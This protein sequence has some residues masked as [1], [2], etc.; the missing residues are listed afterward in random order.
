MP[1]VTLLAAKDQQKPVKIWTD[2][3]QHEAL[4]QM[5]RVASLPFI[6]KHVAGM[7]DIHLGRGATV[8]SVIATTDAI[9]PAAVGVD[10]GCG[11]NAVRLSLKAHDLPDNLYQIR[12]DIER[13]I[14]LGAG[15]AH[16][17]E[18]LAGG[19]ALAMR[20]S[21]I[22]EKHSGISRH[23]N[24]RKFAS[25]LGTLGSGNH[26]IELCLDENDDVWVM[27][28]SGSR[29]IGNMIGQYF[30]RLAR[31]EME[32][33]QIHLPDKELGYLKEGSEYFDDY[34]EAVAW[35]QDY[36]MQNR[37]HMMNAVLR[38]LK[39]RLKKFS[40]TREAINCHHNFVEREIHD[41]DRVWVTRKGAIRAREGDL[42]I[43]PGS[44]GARSYIIRGKGNAE[45]FCSC[46]HGA[47]RTMSRTAAR[48]SFTQKDL[49]EQT[50]GIE[51]RKDK[52]VIDEIPAAYKNIDRVMDLQTDLL[53]VVHTLR[54]VVN[55]KG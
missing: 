25:Q 38:S 53:E 32:R 16:K 4:A 13:T 55:V 19:S 28:H 42:G 21:H 18:Q 11:M 15:G 33:H 30:I 26:F 45:S 34:V 54:Q 5:R 37:E 2:E 48:N 51:C 50:E 24:A 47:G 29:G 39:H 40:V 27:L 31:R 9:I 7:P 52:G 14:P 23:G 17:N 49:R 41:G 35:A 12:N 8:G 43:I 6:Y 20:L 1:V 22:L 3:V 36:A 44:M 10:I 46:A